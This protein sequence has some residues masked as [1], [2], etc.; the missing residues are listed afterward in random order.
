M[1]KY[2]KAVLMAALADIENLAAPRNIDAV[3]AA[4]GVGVANFVKK[5]SAGMKAEIETAIAN[6][7]AIRVVKKRARARRQ[8]PVA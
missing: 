8:T 7:D 4:L 3:C 6:A 1:Q 5:G 2:E